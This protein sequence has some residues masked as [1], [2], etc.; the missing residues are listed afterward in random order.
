VQG[1]VQIV[2]LGHIEYR[3]TDLE[4][5]SHFYVDLLGFHET[6]RDRDYWFEEYMQVES[7]ETGELVEVTAPV[8][9]AIPTY[10]D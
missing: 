3:V 7:L 9:R 6:E 4:R 2:R 1:S 8:S 5:A 10:V